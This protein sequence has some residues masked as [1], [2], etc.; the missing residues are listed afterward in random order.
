MNNAKQNVAMIEKMS[1]Q[2]FEHMQQLGEINLHAMEQLMGNQMNTLQMFMENGL[3]Q[4]NLASEAKGFSELIQGN[5]EMTKELTEGVMN[6]GRQNVKL[7]GDTRDEY[8]NWFEKGVKEM[9]Q[10]MSNAQASV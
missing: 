10:N 7:A 3:R 5:M 2:G 9:T 1:R 6:V 8:R 4:A